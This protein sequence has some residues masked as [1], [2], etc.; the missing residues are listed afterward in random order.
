MNEGS[1]E[2]TVQ[3]ATAFTSGTSHGIEQSLKFAKSYKKLLVAPGLT[4]RNKKLLV[5]QKLGQFKR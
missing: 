1:N 4:S 5:A 2:R 3:K